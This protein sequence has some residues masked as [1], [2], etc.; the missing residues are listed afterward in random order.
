MYLILGYIPCFA[1]EDELRRCRGHPGRLQFGQGGI[2][3]PLRRS[4]RLHGFSDS[5]WPHSG[6]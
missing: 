6:R 5:D 3:E 2:K 1:I 4:E